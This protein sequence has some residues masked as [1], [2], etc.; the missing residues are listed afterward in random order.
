[1]N[2]TPKMKSNILPRFMSG[3]DIEPVAE[4]PLPDVVNREAASPC[5]KKENIVTPTHEGDPSS[6]DEVPPM[7]AGEGV[8]TVE[9]IVLVWTRKELYVAYAW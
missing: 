1:M 9:A 6:D 3:R 5:E 8:K 7:I 2:S 4:T